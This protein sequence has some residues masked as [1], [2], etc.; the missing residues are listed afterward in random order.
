MQYVRI[1]CKVDKVASFHSWDF[2]ACDIATFVYP[3]SCL[4]FNVYLMFRFISGK[5]ALVGVL[6][7]YFAFLDFWFLNNEIDNAIV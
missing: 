7:F 1:L 5:E 2:V 4:L 6:E 3:A